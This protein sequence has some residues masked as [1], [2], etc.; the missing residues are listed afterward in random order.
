M[1]Q[2]KLD[3][4]HTIWL[5]TKEEF[6]TLPNGTKLISILGEVVTKGIDDIDDMDTRGGYLAFGL[7]E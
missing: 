3:D 1:N 6:K 4:G 5:L 2:Y 7:E